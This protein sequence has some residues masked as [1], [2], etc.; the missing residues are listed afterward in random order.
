MFGSVLMMGSWASHIE[1]YFLIK[2][3]MQM[4]QVGPEV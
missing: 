3:K 4:R 1:A 2:V